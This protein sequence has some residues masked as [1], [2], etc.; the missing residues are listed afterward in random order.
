MAPRD[1]FEIMIKLAVISAF[2]KMGIGEYPQRCPCQG[3]AVPER[4]EA[5]LDAE[6]ARTFRREKAGRIRE[7]QKFF[8]LAAP[9]SR[10]EA[11]AR[12]G[13]SD[14]RPRASRNPK[15]NDQS[16]V[17]L[18][19]LA[20]RQFA[21]EVRQSRFLKAHQPIALD[22]AFVLESFGRAHGNLRWQVVPLREYRGADNRGVSGVDQWLPAHDDED[23]CRLWVTGR[24]PNPV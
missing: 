3:P 5:F 22:C 20:R 4:Q 13:S 7:C 8:K 15:C 10:L 2:S 18:A 21:H 23:T 11:F 14:Q 1:G 9:H 24:S 12:A 19:Q 17:E 16:I 6:I